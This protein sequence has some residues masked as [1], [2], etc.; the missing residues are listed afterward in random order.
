MY[1]VW[2]VAVPKV[3]HSFIIFLTNSPH[4][5]SSPNFIPTLHNSTLLNLSDMILYDPRK[6]SHIFFMNAYHEIIFCRKFKLQIALYCMPVPEYEI[7][8][9]IRRIWWYDMIY[10]NQ[11]IYSSQVPIYNIWIVNKLS[12]FVNNI[13]CILDFMYFPHPHPQTKMYLLSFGFHVI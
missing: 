12:Q 4:L 9:I 11:I 2:L 1:F 8:T 10:H 6:K 5:N 3:Y 13:S 7:T